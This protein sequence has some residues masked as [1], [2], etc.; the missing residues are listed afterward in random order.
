MR[1]RPARTVAAPEAPHTHD[2]PVRRTLANG[3]TTI[4]QPVP[5]SGLLSAQVW[6]ATGSIHEGAWLGGGLSHYLEHLLF[7]GT[8]R[9]RGRDIA[10][11]VQALGGTINAYTSF[12]RTVYHIDGPAEALD[13]ALDVL[14]DIVF[15]S[16]LPEE[17]TTRE[18]EVILREI[19]M[20]L[21]EPDALLWQR[22]F[23]TAF[24]QHPYRY[25]VIG[26]R[27][28][29]ERVTRTDLLGYYRARYVPNNAIVVVA[30]DA[31]ADALAE[32]VDRR[33]AT[34]PRGALAPVT[35]PDEPAQTARREARLERPLELSRG[36]LV[37]RTPGQAH[38]DAPALTVL[39]SLLGGG[40]SSWLW[41]EVREQRGLVHA[42][43]AS[44]WMPA[45]PGVLFVGYHADPA[46]RAAAEE[47][48]GAIAS[49]AATRRIREDEVAKIVRQAVVAEVH[50]R[51]TVSGQAS[52]LGQA[53]LL[54]GDLAFWDTYLARL[55]TVTAADVRRVAAQYLDAAR[56][57]C[58]SLDPPR[59]ATARP[60]GAA[61]TASRF[62]ETTVEGVRLLVAHDPRLPL[63]NLRVLLSGGGLA[64]PADRRGA[65][66]LLASVLARDTTKRTAAE[67]DE[68]ADRAGAR[69]GPFAGNNSCGLAV[70]VMRED[71]RLGIDLV[72]E[73]LLRPAFRTASVRRERESQVAS[74]RD[75][76]DDPV[77]HGRRVLRE[78]VFAGH[79]FAWG[80]DGV[81]EHVE[82]LDAAALR[83]VRHALL[84][85]E[86]VVLVVCGDVRADEVRRLL[87][88][89]AAKIPAGRAGLAAWG[90]PVAPA[91]ARHEVRRACEQAVV[92]HGYRGPG[93]HAADRHAC[94]VFL[95][96]VN[97]MASRLFERVRDQLGLAYFVRAGCVTGLG[98]SLVFLECGTRPDAVAA[99]EAEFADELR[100]I[101]DGLG[102]EE[103][104][105]CRRR[106]VASR[107][108]GLQSLGA[109][110]QHAGVNA[111]LGLPVDDAA[112][113]EAGIAAVD[114]AALGAFVR[115]YL[116]AGARTEVV[117]LP[118]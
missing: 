37:W 50:S 77:T 62:E 49:G 101:A 107:R 10:A 59:P 108:Q 60:P 23:E 53:E 19:D 29:F 52:R 94:E 89:L 30:G 102:G 118:G 113:F 96:V 55:R 72:T 16:T 112:A 36:G 78:R 8:T 18:R 3:L 65:C 98:G 66:S 115:T 69:F 97:G 114:A 87:R 1:R 38:A 57:T 84:R 86:S 64:E 58:V 42:V 90:E 41:S 85:R 106:L 32:S 117:V 88:P 93:V 103:L 12:D 26:H 76:L 74:I 45:D 95:E 75:E 44:A 43:D 47:A 2:E 4:A 40:N 105:R 51:K 15:A 99:V 48:I 24:R 22:V 35:L 82:A 111:L 34:L 21:D 100:R 11:E 110:T 68:A 17:E 81:L 116:A 80:S 9:R 25:P 20:T 61:I 83:A 79:P 28:V 39:A 54:T 56:A 14:A 73:G 92:L 71:L 70:E 5:G 33:F 31:S 104:A 91:A 67:V 109:R 7:Q 27:A 46:R 6:I 63:V 13:G